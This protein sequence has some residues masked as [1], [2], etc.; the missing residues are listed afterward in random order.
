M[1]VQ[2][3]YALDDNTSGSLKVEELVTYLDQQLLP[4]EVL[5][6]DTDDSGVITLQEW[7]DGWIHNPMSEKEMAALVTETTKTLI[8]D[9]S[10]TYQGRS[11]GT[12]FGPKVTLHLRV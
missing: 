3:F 5:S 2:L 8:E 7:L 11:D 1:L 9:T 4:P 12:L 6:Y 10:R